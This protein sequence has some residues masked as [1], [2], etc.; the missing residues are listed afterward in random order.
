MN[1]L[2]KGVNGKGVEVVEA[3]EAVEAVVAVEAVEVVEAVEAVQDG[4]N[5][6][7]GA[8][9]CMAVQGGLQERVTRRTLARRRSWFMKRARPLL[10]LTK[11]RLARV[12][13]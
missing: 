13:S 11:A 5:G 10:R 2:G 6:V 1:I 8:W 9:R 12:S 3:V 7:G 4:A